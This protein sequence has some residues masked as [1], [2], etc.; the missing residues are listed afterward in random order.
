MVDVR[1]EFGSVV[2]LHKNYY[3]PWMDRATVEANIGQVRR[4]IEKVEKAI[5]QSIEE[6]LTPHFTPS[7]EALAKLLEQIARPLETVH[8]IIKALP[9][10]HPIAAQAHH[11]DAVVEAPDPIHIG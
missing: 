7:V 1:V 10:A 8:G 5:E 4:L 9:Q 3:H 6:K 2:S 11:Q